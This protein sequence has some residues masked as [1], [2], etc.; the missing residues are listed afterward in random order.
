LSAFLAGLFFA[1][2]GFFILN[3][4]LFYKNKNVNWLM[5]ILFI[6]TKLAKI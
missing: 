5:I 3:E 2:L 4:N 6:Y 1:V